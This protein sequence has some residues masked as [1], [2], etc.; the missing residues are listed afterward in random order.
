M[1]NSSCDVVKAINNKHHA[2]T[3]TREIAELLVLLP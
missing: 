2:L 3:S 1:E